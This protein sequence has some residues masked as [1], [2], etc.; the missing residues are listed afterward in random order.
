MDDVD[1]H[2]DMI[3]GD[4]LGPACEYCGRYQAHDTLPCAKK[5]IERLQAVVDK[6]PKTADGVPAVLGMTLYYLHGCGGIHSDVIAGFTICSADPESS[7]WQG[8]EMDAEDCYSTR[9]AAEKGGDD[10]A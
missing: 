3:Q 7:I 10:A 2:M 8:G 6:L 5:E 1:T 4:S 9:E